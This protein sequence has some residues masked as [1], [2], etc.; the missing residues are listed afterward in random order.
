MLHNTK[1]S[2]IVAIDE[3]RGIGKG[4]DLLV[5][6]PE[7]LKRFRE[8]TRGH[9]VIMGRKTYDSIISYNGKPLPG[10]L[11]IVLSREVN[12]TPVGNNYP[13]LFFSDNW[14]QVFDEAKKW[15][16]DHF[17]EEEREIFI[18]GG[19]QIFKQVLEENVIDRM[20]LTQ[21]KGDYH[22]DAFF[23]DYSQFTKVIEKEERDADGYQYTFLTVEK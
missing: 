6:I 23:P 22:A 15:E 1:I 3:K 8:I 10:R 4:S 2:I 20:Y 7:D 9:A 16:K 12:R 11:N 14:D 21:V 19:A 17:P 13:P 5:K 18:I